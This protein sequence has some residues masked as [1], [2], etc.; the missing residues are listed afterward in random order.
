[1]GK[2]I[3]N[4]EIIEELGRGTFTRSYK[5][6]DTKLNRICVMRILEKD[7]FPAEVYE[8]IGSPDILLISTACLWYK[9]YNAIFSSSGQRCDFF[10]P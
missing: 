1:M 7:A 4:Y 9:V 3:G 10:I 6:R 8:L 2:T 5:V